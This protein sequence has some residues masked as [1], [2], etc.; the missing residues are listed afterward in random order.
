MKQYIFEA[1]GRPGGPEQVGRLDMRAAAAGR[2]A[3]LCFYGDIVSAAWAAWDDTDKCPQDISDFMSGLAPTEPL[4]IYFNCGGGDA[5]AGIAI[6]N[7]LK[8]HAG[9]KRGI[10]DGLAAS[11]ASVI[12]MA[13]DEIIVNTGGQVMVHKPWSWTAGNARDMREA[14]DMLDGIEGSMID[15]YMTKALNGV[16]RETVAALVDAETWMDG[17]EARQYFDVAVGD[18]PA[19]AASASL[20]YSRYRNMPASLA[21][22]VPPEGPAPEPPAGPEEPPEKPAGDI[23]IDL[24]LADSYIAILNT[25]K[26]D[27]EQ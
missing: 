1:R 3:S 7:I 10:V 24:S 13:C 23:G 17:E 21:A 8:R 18:R 22:E 6:H 25:Y 14:A 11:S 5:F 15:V 4:D 16:A 19:A 12:L 26:E 2:S 20:C 27:N 9:A